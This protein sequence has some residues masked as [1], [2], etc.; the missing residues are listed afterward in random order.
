MKRVL[1]YN[2]SGCENR[3]CEAIVRTTA[4][5]LKAQGIGRV[6]LSSGQPEYDRRL[7]IPDVDRTIP[8]V[9]SPMSPRRFVNS[10]GF[11]LGMPREHEVARRYAPVISAGRRSGLCLSVGGDTYCYNPQ[12][13]MRVINGRLRRAGVPIVLWGASVDPER[14]QGE[15]LEDLRAYDLIVARESESAGAMEEAGLKV[16][17]RC[18]PA[19]GLRPVCLPLPPAWREEE[20]VGLNISPL[21][22]DKMGDRKRGT[23]LFAELVRHVLRTTPFSVALFSH[24]LW[25][26][27]DD[28]K[29]AV[30]LKQAFA[31]EKRVFL[32]PGTPGA[33]ELKGYIGRM[34]LLVTAR[35]HASIAGYSSAVPTLVIG[36]SV[37]ARGIAKDLFGGAEGHLLESGALHDAAELCRAFDALR[38]REAEE[39]RYLSAALPG[40]LEDREGALSAALG[41]MREGA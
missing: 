29:V 12:E 13:H 3:G 9:I 21:V 25:P 15:T 1:L 8:A 30:A 37:K 35:T 41:L 5:L 23:E 24:V 27:D 40:Y 11:R 6:V 31:Q 20:T 16:L 39:R 7:S 33:R 17:R 14:L 10:A 19:F 22:L 36:Y 2:H 26:H 28:R 32:L 4:A 18:D 34:R 38:E